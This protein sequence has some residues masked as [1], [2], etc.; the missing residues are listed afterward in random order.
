MEYYGEVRDAIERIAECDTSDA[1]GIIGAWEMRNGGTMMGDENMDKAEAE[2]KDPER[3]A[4]EILGIPDCPSYPNPLH[5]GTDRTYDAYEVAEVAQY[6]DGLGNTHVEQI[7][8]DHDPAS[9]PSHTGK[10]WWTIYG[11]KD[12]HGIEALVDVDTKDLALGILRS[13]GV[14]KWR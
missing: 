10:R 14:I 11:H 1:Q 9:K 3:L 4:R 8:E 2:G 6:T 12:G 13:M 7:Q 5:D